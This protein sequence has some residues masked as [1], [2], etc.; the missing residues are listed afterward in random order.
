MNNKSGKNIIVFST[1]TCPWCN[2]LKKYLN[3]KGI[4]FN[5]LDVSKDHDSAMKMVMKSGQMGVPQMWINEDIVVGFD[6]S[7]I[8]I[9][10]GL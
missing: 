1:P 10:L 6:K 5:D 2:V 7:R 9:L 8:D 3:D 4:S